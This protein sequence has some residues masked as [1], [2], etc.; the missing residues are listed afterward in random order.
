MDSN[1]EMMR[2]RLPAWNLPSISQER[3]PCSPKLAL[4]DQA[5]PGK[6]VV[7]FITS[8]GGKSVIEACPFAGIIQIKFNGNFSERFMPKQSSNTRH[9]HI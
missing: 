4:V 8:G 7:K 1:K 3:K 2:W 9:A 6:E 5:R